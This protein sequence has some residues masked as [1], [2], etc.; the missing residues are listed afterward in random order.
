[1]D[2]IKIVANNKKIIKENLKKGIKTKKNRAEKCL[3]SK[4]ELKEI[5]RGVSQSDE[6]LVGGTRKRGTR[7]RG[8]RKR[9]TRKR[10][11]RRRG[12]RRRGTRRRG[13]RRR[14]YKVIITKTT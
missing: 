5:N 10:G 3:D 2:T 14:G 1:M 9:G 4:A 13:T 12:T 8:T 11:T 6:H 7:R